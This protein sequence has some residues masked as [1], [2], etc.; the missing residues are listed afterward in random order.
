MIQ[1]KYIG[2]ILAILFTL[3][4]GTAINLNYID[5]FSSKPNDWGEAK[6][7]YRILNKDERGGYFVD[8]LNFTPDNDHLFSTNIV[9]WDM[10]DGTWAK[11]NNVNCYYKK[12][13][14]YKVT[15]FVY[16]DNGEKLKSSKIIEIK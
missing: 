1:R 15:L 14:Q 6:W 13:G 4:A 10:G 3:I 5:Q 2:P 8:L 7:E 9:Y 16:R 11:T 12:P